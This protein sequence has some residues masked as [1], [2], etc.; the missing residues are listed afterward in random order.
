MAHSTPL[1]TH[2]SAMPFR[3][4]NDKVSESVKPRGVVDLSKIQVC[5]LSSFLSPSQTSQS[6]W[7][8][9]H[10]T[11]VD[12][13]L[14]ASWPLVRA[15]P[16]VKD[17][18][19]TPIPMTSNQQVAS[20]TAPTPSNSRQLQAAAWPTSA[21]ARQTWCC[22]CPRCRSPYR[23]A[24]N[25]SCV[26]SDDDGCV[27]GPGGVSARVRT[28]KSMQMRRII[29]LVAGVED[30]P[31]APSSSAA[32]K[33]SSTTKRGGGGSSAEWV[34]QLERNFESM[35]A[36]G[37]SPQLPSNAMVDVVG[38]EGFGGGGD[39]GGGASSSG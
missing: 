24:W 27:G 16:S 3:F 33:S 9:S 7:G 25:Q 37:G 36:R 2:S 39:G 22:G 8:V 12:S 20:S 35:S 10:E 4:M 29:K 32:N 28:R 1:I 34:H 21:R 26:S 17:A 15:S 30:E 38:Y 13:L 5:A 31:R 6:G 23:W 19:V 11:C 14:E 18:A